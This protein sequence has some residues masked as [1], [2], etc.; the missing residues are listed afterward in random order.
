M[1][2]I[3]NETYLTLTPA[4][5][6]IYSLKADYEQNFKKGRLGLGGKVSYVS[7]NSIFQKFISAP[8]TREDNY[9]NFDYK[10]NINALYVNYNRQL[11]GVMVQAGVR[12][13]NKHPK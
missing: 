2:L 8:A 13:E 5:I 11:K 1:A 9:N 10:E 4:D 12:I 6:D 3:S 7:T